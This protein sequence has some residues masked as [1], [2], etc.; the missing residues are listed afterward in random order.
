[1]DAQDIEKTVLDTIS[2]REL[3]QAIDEYLDSDVCK[4]QTLKRDY[5]NIHNML[6]EY[7]DSFFLV[8]YNI[9]GERVL[10]SKYPSPK[11]EDAIS[12]FLCH[13]MENKYND[14]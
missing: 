6:G 2:S 13:V 5:V 7:L 1:M 9:K 14:D 4:K 10:I 3:H 8:G 11:D 12:Q